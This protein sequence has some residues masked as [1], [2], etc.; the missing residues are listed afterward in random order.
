MN[1]LSA[2]RRFFESGATKDYRFRKE[3][4]VKLREAIKKFEQPLHE[5]L[6]ADLKKSP[7]ECWVTETGFLQ[8]EINSCRPVSTSS[9]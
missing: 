3:Q 8:A 7:E 2:M 9:T 1:A 4:L 5:A 6:Y